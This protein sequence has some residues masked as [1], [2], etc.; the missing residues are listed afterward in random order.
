MI[1]KFFFSGSPGT[2]PS[3]PLSFTVSAR[4]ETGSFD[5]TSANASQSTPEDGISAFIFRVEAADETSYILQVVPH[6]LS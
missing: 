2:L 6:T 1:K 4:T 3:S 5:I